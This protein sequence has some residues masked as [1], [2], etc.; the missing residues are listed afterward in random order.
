[1]TAAIPIKSCSVHSLLKTIVDTRNG[2]TYFPELGCHLS[3]FLL[4]KQSLIF[5]KVENAVISEL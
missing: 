2:A 5:V 1:M 3:K 4:S